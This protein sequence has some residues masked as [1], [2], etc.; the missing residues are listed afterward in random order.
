[1]DY[2]D[3]LVSPPETNS[4]HAETERES[5]PEAKSRDGLLPKILERSS[6]A[7]GL[8][9]GSNRT[10][11]KGKPDELETPSSKRQMISSSLENRRRLR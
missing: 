4:G 3:G 8:Q 7:S 1:M 5:F 6:S 9:D 2:D 11:K 10:P